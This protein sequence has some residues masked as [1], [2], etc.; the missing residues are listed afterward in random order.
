[1]ST[2][3]YQGSSPTSKSCKPIATRARGPSTRL[4][5]FRPRRARPFTACA[6]ASVTTGS[7]RRSRN[8]RRRSRHLLEHERPHVFSMNLGNLMPRDQ[9]EIELRYTELLVPT[10]G[11][12]EM[13]YP[14]VVGPRYS[15]Q[16]EASAPADDKFVKNPYTT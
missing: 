3:P 1:M 7:S 2:S 10:D 5:S 15:S 13:V 12:Y 8:A 11:L 9:V 6:C 14:T 4:T 16:K